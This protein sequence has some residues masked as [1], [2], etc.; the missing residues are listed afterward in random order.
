[1]AASLVMPVFA[2]KHISLFLISLSLGLCIFHLREEK[3]VLAL[4][5][6]LPLPLSSALSLE[7]SIKMILLQ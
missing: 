6:A 7:V 3:S 4:E 5:L 1:M 2:P